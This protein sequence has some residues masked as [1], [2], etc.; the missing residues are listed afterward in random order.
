MIFEHLEKAFAT[1]SE[2]KVPQEEESAAIAAF[3][4]EFITCSL[5]NPMTRKIAMQVQS[6]SHTFTCSKRGSRCRFQF[7]RFPCLY[8]QVA[9][10]VRL[11]FGENEEE[12]KK[13]MQKMRIVL[14]KVRS[15]LEDKETMIKVN[16]IHEDEIEEMIGEKELYLKARHILEDFIFK[17]QISD[18]NEN[19]DLGQKLIEN[20][21]SFSEEH[22]AKFKLLERKDQGYRK[23]RLLKVLHFAKIEKELE[24]DED[25]TQEEK[26]MQLIVKYHKILTYSI[27]G[28]TVNLKRD[29]DECYINN[30]NHEF[31]SN[32]NANMD[33]SCVFDFFAILTYVR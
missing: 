6:H 2:S 31:L 4:D 14:Q 1:C 11:T 16:K 30:F 23:A 28:F 25:L 9:V 8:T 26:D 22:E 19:A 27:K 7:P 13:E 10:P 15:V 12:K 17:K 20:L 32:W 3:V 5:R 21:E 24:I 29:T 18:F 33:V